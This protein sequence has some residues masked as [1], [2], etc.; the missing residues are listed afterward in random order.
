MKESRVSKF[1]QYRKTISKDSKANFRAPSKDEVSNEMRLF[2]H[3][4]NR[5]NIENIAII[6]VIL[7]ISILLIVFGINLFGR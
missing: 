5:R 2:L 3:I 7:T 6:L 4:R 1:E